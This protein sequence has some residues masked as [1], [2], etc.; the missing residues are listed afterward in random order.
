MTRSEQETKSW[1][2]GG[3][4]KSVGCSENG[5]CKVMY[6]F[7]CDKKWAQSDEKEADFNTNQEISRCKI[8]RFNSVCGID[9]N[10]HRLVYVTCVQEPKI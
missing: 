3:K 4:S 9:K 1:M 5:V 8:Q 2:K 6:V 7:L 10:R